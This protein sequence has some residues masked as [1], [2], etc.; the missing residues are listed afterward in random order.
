M[1]KLLLVGI[2]IILAVSATWSGTQGQ[3][4][5]DTFQKALSLERATGDLSGAIALYQKVVETS[6]DKALAA[7]AQLRI[8]LCY[9]KLGQKNSKQ[10]QEAFQKVI[11]D[12]PGQQTAVKEAREKL[13][14][15]LSAQAAVDKRDKGMVMRKLWRADDLAGDFGNFS[16]DGRYFA[17]HH[18]AS[19]DLAVRDIITGEVRRLNL[20]TNY[21]ETP[22]MVGYCCWSPDGKQIAYDWDST[23]REIRIVNFDGS[24]PR[25]VYKSKEGQVW[26]SPYAWSPD[27]RLILI[28]LKKERENEYK[29]GLLNVENGSLREFDLIV[30]PSTNSG[31]SPDGRF[32]NLTSRQKDKPGNPDIVLY[33][34]AQDKIIPL[35]KNPAKDW[36]LGWS[37]D[38]RW[39]IFA[40]DRSGTPDIWALRVTDGKVQGDP[41]LIKKSMETNQGNAWMTRTGAFCY[42]INMSYQDVYVAEL[43][44]DANRV[45]EGPKKATQHYVNTNF[46]PAWSA[47]GEFLAFASKRDEE[48]QTVLC[49][50]SN[51]TGEVREYLLKLRSFGN[52]TKIF[53]TRDGQSVIHSGFDGSRKPDF[54][55][56]DLK[57]GAMSPV[58]IPGRR[59]GICLSRDGKTVFYNA[60]HGAG[61][62]SELMAYDLETEKAETLMHMAGFLQGLALAPD[63]GKLVFS[64]EVGP[65]RE[66]VCALKI[67]PVEGGEPRTIFETAKGGWIETLDWTPDGRFILFT[68]MT[69]EKDGKNTRDHIWM[70]SAQGGEP[71]ETGI[72]SDSIKHLRVS[73]DGRHIA[74]TSGKRGKEVWAIENFLPKDGNEK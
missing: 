13:S 37:P 69:A 40:S 18:W 43:D 60:N 16:P 4:A 50:L 51:R 33:S 73:P 57:T 66:H 67:F 48:P 72:S 41:V 9:E 26:T 19:G 47:D 14:A 53:W 62:P 54:Y 25:T 68:Q 11:D 12:F 70:I 55:R 32:I 29:F 10:A 28:F 39:F 45:V 31:F 58:F 24:N 15:L 59:R 36:G 65:G 7:Q 38:G 22:Q 2:F 71:R 61:G 63:G 23:P 34:L 8:G 56:T 1:K 74:F 21:V 17:F 44:F 64:E 42:A 52:S 30:N 49:V 20:K 46:A 35:V 5:Q 3:T 6:A 27:G